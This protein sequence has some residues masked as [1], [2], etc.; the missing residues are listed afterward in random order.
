MKNSARF[1]SKR[2]N[3][4]K[5][6]SRM[7][8]NALKII[9]G[10]GTLFALAFIIPVSARRPSAD[11]AG[12]SAQSKVI[13]A[14]KECKQPEACTSI[15]DRQ[16]K[17]SPA[18]YETAYDMCIYVNCQSDG[19]F[20]TEGLLYQWCL[21][22]QQKETEQLRRDEELR[23]Q[24]ETERQQEEA[25]RQ[26]EQNRLLQETQKQTEQTIKQSE[27]SNV[28]AKNTKVLQFGVD[29]KEGDTLKTSKNERKTIEFSDGSKINMQPDS[30]LTFVKPDEYQALKGKFSFFF[31]RLLEGRRAIRVRSGTTAMSIRGTEFLVYSTRIKTI[32]QVLDGIVNVATLK[33][34]KSVDVTA[35]YQITV[36]KTKIQKPVLFTDKQLIISQ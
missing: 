24:R 33:G 11:V 21:D 8:K 16:A 10:A 2:N 1:C 5:N 22:D 18:G 14:V 4:R 30:G 12:A 34:A 15:C 13:V 25:R 19:Y 36:T 32:V 6:F 26:E 20:P 27:P 17:T 7:T 9:I 29:V 28:A 23:I 35:G 3:T 31:T